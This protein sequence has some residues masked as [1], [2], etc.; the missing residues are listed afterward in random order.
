MT[1]ID[2]KD[3]SRQPK[4][5]ICIPDTSEV[6]TVMTRLRKQNPELN[7]SDWSVTRGRVTE[8]EQTLA[9]ST[10]PDSFKALAQSNYKAFWGLGRI[11]FRTLKEAK[12]QLE[13]ESTTSN[14]S[15]Q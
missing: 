2:S 14:P 11:N 1:V 6:N 10:D 13:D 8:K 3:L 5:L 12:K 9:F 4:V 7:M 15:S